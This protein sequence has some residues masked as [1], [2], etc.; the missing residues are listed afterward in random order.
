MFNR[1]MKLLTGVTVVVLIATSAAL[2][3][4]PATEKKVKD[5]QEFDLFTQATT[6]TDAAKRLPILDSWKQKYPESDFKEERF[7]IY[8]TTYQALNQTLKAVETGKELLALNP[9]EV[10]ALFFLTRYGQIQPATPDSL[11]TGE[12]AAMGL[13]EAAKP[14]TVK[15]EDWKKAKES[16]NLTAH[17]TLGFIA[18]QKKQFDVAEK[19]YAKLLEADP[20]QSSTSYALGSAILAQK[21]PERYPEALFHIARAASRTGPGALAPELQKQVDGFLVRS[22]TTFHGADDA[23]L[24][25]LRQV[26]V[27][28][29][30]P[31][32][33]FTIKDKNAIDQEIQAKLAR[34]NPQLAF[35]KGLK[36][37]L[38]ADNGAQY[39]EGGVKG[40]ALPPPEVAKKLKGK[41][42]SM[43]PAVRPKELVLAIE[44]GKPEVTLKFETALPGKAEPGTEIEFE[45]IADS[46]TKEPFMLTF[47]V[48]EKEKITGWP[49]Q[50]A[51][52]PV[53]KAA[54]KKGTK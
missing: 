3:Q 36:E 39:F 4:A 44:E 38:T 6:V 37:G 40:A 53:R 23:G 46:F 1:K 30:L 28:Q 43:K 19:E 9:K 48:D 33:G 22:Y 26:A 32:A 27:S 16:F 49:A 10:N 5:Q 34:D 20:N 14:A 17:Q 51:A 42:V 18:N 41:L 2:A 45:G 8:L 24:K 11:A 35:W 54:A 15:D 29:P 50:A 52:P 25:E 47:L 31:P 7:I 21:K 13:L 12:K